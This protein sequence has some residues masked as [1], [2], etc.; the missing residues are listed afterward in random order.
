LGHQAALP[1][2][3]IHRLEEQPSRPAVLGDI[4]CDSDGKVDAFIDRRD[5]KRTPAAAPL[6]RRRLLTSALS[7]SAPTEKSWATCTTCSATPTRFTSAW[8][9]PAR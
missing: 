4:T 1:H 6:H 7:C 3:A 8:D 9:R 2:H 5:V